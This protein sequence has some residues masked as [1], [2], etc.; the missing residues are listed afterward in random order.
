MSTKKDILRGKNDFFVNSC[1]EE[2]F[3]NNN[4]RANRGVERAGDYDVVFHIKGDSIEVLD[5]GSRVPQA[6]FDHRVIPT[7]GL[8]RWAL[9]RSD[10][11]MDCRF[12]LSPEDNINTGDSPGCSFS[13]IGY[14]AARQS[15]HLP[16]P[17]PHFLGYVGNSK[18]ERAWG[19]EGVLELKINRA[20][21]RGTDT[22][23]QRVR[24]AQQTL[25]N[26]FVDVG[27]T[28]FLDRK[29][30]KSFFKDI[31]KSKI[32]RDWIGP[33]EQ[34]KH[35]YILDIYGHTIAWD[36]PCW[37]LPANS[38]LVSVRPCVA[39]TP[40]VH[41]WYSHF[42]YSQGIIPWIEEEDLRK[43]EDWSP[44]DELNYTQKDFGRLLLDPKTLL[45]FTNKFLKRYA[46]EY[47]S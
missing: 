6:L 27:I 46:E 17:D 40:E 29:D 9:E 1:I 44:Y 20:I 4:I 8:F 26:I 13:K 18:W 42:A 39:E 12:I 38:L 10:L 34:L 22:S 21:F 23:K 16:V 33:Q 37:A 36:R 25:D 14:S 7:L 28:N 47:N 31:D 43:A 3:S 24:I 45:S 5:V 2:V 19:E 41:T 11:K 35:K 15:P 32:Q 30:E